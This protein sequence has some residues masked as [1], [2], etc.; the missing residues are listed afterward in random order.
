MNPAPRG[1][2]TFR[3]IAEHPEGDPVVAL[4]MDY[5]VPDAADFV[6]TASR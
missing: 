1:P 5:A 3:R 6:L 4:A 2:E